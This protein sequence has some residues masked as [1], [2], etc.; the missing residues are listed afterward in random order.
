MDCVYELTDTEKWRCENCGHETKI[1]GLRRNCVTAPILRP[2]HPPSRARRLANF[3]LAAMKH[4]M[5]ACPTR[6]QEE[7]DELVSICRVCTFF[8]PSED[9]ETGVCGHERCGC[10][11][12]RQKRYITKLGWKSQHCPD[13][14]W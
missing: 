8:I 7:I 12:T 9:D 5:S 3:T 1:A 13:G 6:S 14:R 2:Q 11:V 4:L 10:T